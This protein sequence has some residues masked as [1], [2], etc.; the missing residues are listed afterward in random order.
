MTRDDPDLKQA[1]G[2]ET[3]EDSVR[4]YRQWATTY[5]ETFA[6]EMDYQYPATVAEVFATAAGAGDQP[7]LDVGAG[8][9][10]VGQALTRSG[11]WVIDGLDI[12]GEMLDVAME[13]GCYR[14]AIVA[15]L[16]QKL[17]LQ[18]E[19]YGSVVS[20]GTF[21]HGHVGADAL[22]ELLRI[23]K[24]GALFA[25]GINAQV[26][27]SAGFEQK[28]D[29]LGAQISG[30]HIVERKIYGENSD[31]EHREDTALIAVFR[32]A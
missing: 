6:R 27:S 23:A 2:L 32:K 3:P 9:G 22:D 14:K 28:F 26:F 25:L 8:T 12:S 18:A 20:A 24:P 21:T 30:F 1:Y 29:Q 31:P 7:V 13:K 16:T 5:D 17:A 4:L 10:L 19:C 15:D 11:E